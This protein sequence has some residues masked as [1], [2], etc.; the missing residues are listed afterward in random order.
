MSKRF[1]SWQKAV[2]LISVG[3]APMFLP[4]FNCAQNADFQGAVTTIGNNAIDRISDTT[5]ANGAD[6]E[7]IIRGPA[8]AFVQAVWSN[9]VAT[10]FA[11]DPVGLPVVEQ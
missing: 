9:Y 6:Y 11:Q 3:G 10:R 7:A 1:S 2:L 4:L 8:T 5:F